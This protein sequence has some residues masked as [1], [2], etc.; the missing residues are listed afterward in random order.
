MRA[1][2]SRDTRPE[3]ALRSE[4]F[5]RGLR[6]RVN[7]RPLPSMRRTADLAFTRPKLA[8]FVDGCFWHGCPDHYSAPVTNGD[9]WAAKVS[10]NRERDLDTNRRLN[11]AGWS[12]LRVWEHMAPKE[13]ADLVASEYEIL[14][15]RR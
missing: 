9:F 4:L 1:N 13:A 3:L 8:V 10:R 5:R 14:T 7:F 6:Y 12:V 11:E 15:S 2:R